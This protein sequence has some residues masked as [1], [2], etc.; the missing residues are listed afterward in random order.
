MN[1]IREVD[2]RTWLVLIALVG[3]ALAWVY[4]A[5]AGDAELRADVRMNTKRMDKTEALLESVSLNQTQVAQ[6][7]S[8]LSALFS[9]HIR[10]TEK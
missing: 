9:D 7:L 3:N 1:K 10:R 2:L 6:N 5:G 8:V 4:G